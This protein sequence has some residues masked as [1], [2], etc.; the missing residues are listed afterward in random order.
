MTRWV[1]P[2][3]ARV[4]SCDRAARSSDRSR[5]HADRVLSLST[6]PPPPGLL[7]YG[8]GRGTVGPAICLSLGAISMKENWVQRA[9]LHSHTQT[10]YKGTRAF[11]RHR[12]YMPA[13]I[14]VAPSLLSPVPLFSVAFYCRGLKG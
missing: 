2:L 8:G 5:D 13:T 1:P 4:L 14:V 10:S 3:S 7:V 11:M 12:S 9:P 6:V